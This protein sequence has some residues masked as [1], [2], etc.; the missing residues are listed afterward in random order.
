[1]H[2]SSGTTGVP[3]INAMTRNDIAQWSEM[4]ARCLACAGLTE[5]IEFR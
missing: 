2:L 1:M 4:M 3:V 5:K